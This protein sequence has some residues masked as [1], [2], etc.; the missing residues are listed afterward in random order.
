MLS[1]LSYSTC[2]LTKFVSVLCVCVCVCCRAC[3]SPLL[4]VCTQLWAEWLVK[5]K[6]KA[7]PPLASCAFGRALQKENRAEEK[8]GNF[9][10]KKKGTEGGKKKAYFQPAVF[11]F[12]K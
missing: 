7:R 9:N 2:I 6:A 5:K 11:C 1:M 10:R 8:K 12:L 3:F 4:F